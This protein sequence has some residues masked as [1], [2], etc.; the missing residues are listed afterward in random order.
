MGER[1][2]LPRV[3]FNALHPLAPQRREGLRRERLAA[4]PVALPFLPASLLRLECS[5]L[6]A[7]LRPLP[8]MRRFRPRENFRPP[9]P[10]WQFQ[11]AKAS[12]RLRSLPLPRLPLPF[13]QRPNLP[14]N[15]LRPRRKTSRHNQVAPPLV[16]PIRRTAG[17]PAGFDDHSQPKSAN[18]RRT[19]PVR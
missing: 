14:T 6:S 1:G 16:A 12:P 3:L 5:R 15:P 9:S 17:V 10:R 18:H 4:T 19:Q 8:A 11:M 2:G 7:L 13:L